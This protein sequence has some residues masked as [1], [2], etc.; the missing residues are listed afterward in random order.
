M[1]Q[2]YGFNEKDI[3]IEEDEWILGATEIEREV[4]NPSGDWSDYL[5]TYEPQAVNFETYGCTIFGGTNQIEILH[6]F[7]FGEEP[8]YA[9]RY[10]Y[11]IAKIRSP[12]ASPHKVYETIRKEGLINNELLPMTKTYG[13]YLKP[14]PMDKGLLVKGQHWLNEYE[15][16]HDWLKNP[17]RKQ[18]KDNLKY[19]PIG[20]SVTAWF[21][22]N[23]V[24]VDRGARNTHW[25][26]LFAY[27]GENPLVF[28]SYDR[29][30]KKLHKDHRIAFAKRITLKRRT[31]P[32]VRNPFASFI[33]RLLQCRK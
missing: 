30:V 6:K 24:F 2:N 4:I 18:L 32:R 15:Y 20:M 21:E 5:P 10:N 28:D 1:L 33:R 16:H 14:D 29:K 11:I 7:L 17:T 19:C 25:V 23:G 9:E 31:E 3:V 26:V 12:G 13:E 22:E 8:N 27:E